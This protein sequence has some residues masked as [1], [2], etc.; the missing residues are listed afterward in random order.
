M[1]DTLRQLFLSTLEGLSLDRVIPE[2]LACEDDVLEVG[3]DR[4]EL[5]RYQKIAVVAIGKAAFQMSRALTEMVKGRTVAGL[6]VTSAESEQELDG[7]KTY[8]GGTPLPRSAKLP[9]RRRHTRSA[10]QPGAGRSADLSPLRWWI[11]HL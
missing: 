2:K 8:M 11:G 4:I 5:G 3:G 6:V 10:A 7:F 1:K 9:R